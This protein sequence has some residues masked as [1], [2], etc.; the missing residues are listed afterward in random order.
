MLAQQALAIGVQANL[1]V[2]VVGGPGVGKTATVRKLAETIAAK[3]GKPFPVYVM[4]PSLLDVTDLNGMPYREDGLTKW[5]APFWTAIVKDSGLLF[6][7][8]AN[9]ASP[10]VMSACLRIVLE[11][12]VGETIIKASRVL[13]T[14]PPEMIPGATPFS[15][16]MSNRLMWI[17]WEA[18][19]AADW[20]KGMV[21]GF[22]F[23]LPIVDQSPMPAL[24]KKAAAL[25]GSF[26]RSKPDVL[27]NF[28]K[29]EGEQSGPW[30]SHRSW[31]MAH[32]A[33]AAVEAAGFNGLSDLAF[34]CVAG[35]VG[36]SAATEFFTWLRRADLPDPETLLA[37]PAGFKV[38]TR[39][40]IV[41]AIVTAVAAVVSAKI[42]PGQ[43][44][45]AWQ[46]ISRVTAAG[47][48]DAAT[49]AAQTLARANKALPEG[50]R[51]VTPA[52]A[53]DLMPVA[54]ALYDAAQRRK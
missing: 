42:E 17:E 13:V 12:Q 26:V 22:T 43:W 20:S 38:P 5:A 4:I 10:Q 54:Q 45:A 35:C 36:K 14:N 41:H 7:D 2:H 23:D 47:Y 21:D 29:D 9:T 32:V 3:T 1:P 37:N 53:A 50:Q 48:K 8:E 33:L 44:D 19:S 16:P 39:G 34:T 51:M 30:P 24:L 25:I 31:D 15:A 6:I 46:I 11:G 49:M 27:A 18:L 28:P 40:D 52:F